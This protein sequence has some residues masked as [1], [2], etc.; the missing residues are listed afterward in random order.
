MNAR[1]NLS[2]SAENVLIS[3]ALLGLGSNQ[4]QLNSQSSS[5]D[6]DSQGVFPLFNVINNSFYTDES[7][8]I[9]S[10][11]PDYPSDLKNLVIKSSGNRITDDFT[12]S[13]SLFGISGVLPTLSLPEFGS[14]GDL[15][16][17][18]TFKKGELSLTG[19]GRLTGET[20]SG[21]Y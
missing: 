19:R 14:E 18:Q 9:A 2:L 12:V 8:L 6:L 16:S 15:L 10:I 7:G 17:C 20:P 1:L 4:S 3:A 21:L 5:I 13:G 11:R